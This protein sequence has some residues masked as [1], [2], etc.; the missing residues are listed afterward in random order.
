MTESSD[1]RPEA[2]APTAIAVPVAEFEGE[3]VRTMVGKLPQLALEMPEG[4]K[5]GTH[6]MLGVE[7]RVRNVSYDEDKHGDLV[8]VHHFAQEDAIHL[9]DAWDPAQRPDNVGGSAAGDAWLQPFL[10]WVHGNTDVL[11]FGEA[12]VPDRLQQLLETA[13]GLLGA[14]HSESLMIEAGF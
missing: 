12:E 9:M 10:E 8:R 3:Y 7:V 11:D 14:M 6:L 5:R 13:F 4:Y 1:A 2:I